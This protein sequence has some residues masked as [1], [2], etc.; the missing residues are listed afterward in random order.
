[1]VRSWWH[2][3][4]SYKYEPKAVQ[5]N[6]KHLRFDDKLRP[7]PEDPLGSVIKVYQPRPFICVD[8][9]LLEFHGRV[10]FRQ[11][12]ATKPG[13]IGIKVYWSVDAENSYPIR[14]LVSWATKRWQLKRR[15]NHPPFQRQQWR[16]SCTFFWAKEV[17]WLETTSLRHLTYV[18]FC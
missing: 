2:S 10:K 7:N 12:I 3:I 11:I 5:T 16:N 8:E 9:M 18:T 13:K 4:G 15:L 17:V 14:C 1:M 6:E